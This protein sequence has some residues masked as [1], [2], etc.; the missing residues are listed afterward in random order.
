[1]THIQFFRIIYKIR[2]DYLGM[3]SNEDWVVCQMVNCASHSSGRRG[4]R[5]KVRSPRKE[6]SSWGRT[7]VEGRS[8][9]QEVGGGE[10]GEGAGGRS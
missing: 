2:L 10:Q 7:G 9:R 8:R 1:M 5:G 4:G 3:W 6:S